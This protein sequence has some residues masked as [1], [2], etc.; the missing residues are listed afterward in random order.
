MGRKPVSMVK[1]SLYLTY[2]CSEHSQQLLL[3]SNVNNTI[4]I[5]LGFLHL[6]HKPD[7]K[8]DLGLVLHR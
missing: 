4:F 2:I 3:Q 6:K 5:Y 7:F 8:V 1:S